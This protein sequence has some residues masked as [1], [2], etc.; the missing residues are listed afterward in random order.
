MGNEPRSSTESSILESSWEMPTKRAH[1]TP[2][3]TQIL[4]GKDFIG[5]LEVTRDTN[6]ST[7]GASSL[8]TMCL[9][10]I[11]VI[12]AEEQEWRLQENPD[13]KSDVEAETY[14]MLEDFGTSST[15]GWAPLRQVVRAHGIYLMEAAIRDELFDRER[16]T[17]LLSSCQTLGEEGVRQQITAAYLR[18]N[19]TDID[20]FAQRSIKDPFSKPGQFFDLPMASMWRF[21]GVR[22]ANDS[23]MRVLNEVLRRDST[24]SLSLTAGQVKSSWNYAIGK[25]MTADV[26][27]AVR[28]QE[29]LETILLHAS[30]IEPVTL[31]K[32]LMKSSQECKVLSQSRNAN[33]RGCIKDNLGLRRLNIDGEY[34]TMLEICVYVVT[35]ITLIDAS[36]TPQS[37]HNAR[38]I[39][40]RLIRQASLAVMR[41]YALDDAAGVV[42]K[43]DITHTTA[44]VLFADV[45][46]LILGHR[47]HC[48]TDYEDL[49]RER[50][51]FITYILM[52]KRPT[53]KPTPSPVNTTAKL[54][55]EIGRNLVKHAG[56]IGFKTMQ[57]VCDYLTQFTSHSPEETSLMKLIA[58][59][60][61][62][63]FAQKTNEP[64]HVEYASKVEA[65]VTK[66][67]QD[68]PTIQF[69]LGNR[70]ANL[71]WEEGLCEWV[72]ATPLPRELLRKTK[73]AVRNEASDESV[74]ETRYLGSDGGDVSPL[75]GKF[76]GQ[77]DSP[78][79]SLA[80]LN[81]TSPP[82]QT[83]TPTP[84]SSQDRKRK[85]PGPTSSSQSLHS[86]GSSS[87]K[88]Y[89]TSTGPSRHVADDDEEEED[90]LSAPQP[91]H[92][93][94]RDITNVALGK[95]QK[96]R[97]APGKER[98]VE[99]CELV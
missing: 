41:A 62:L 60:S 93:T 28:A 74:S 2:Q 94:L 70:P 44:T 35:L 72:T 46:I 90:E 78:R 96:P 63:M 45:I 12:M 73:L 52:N 87:Q 25:I 6:C 29:F 79:R 22:W 97:C 5:L 59:E 69:H 31:E 3:N 80:P 83:T 13:D 38:S 56:H 4:A 30:C 65:L 48:E 68:H 36:T 75:A 84:S 53:R 61:S 88:R 37:R 17:A 81:T 92:R 23:K 40:E 77:M 91:S 66:S 42:R 47:T 11:P 51:M 20:S 50:S 43:F 85:A 15:S 54:L 55:V 18:P 21:G 24:F 49:I 34:R 19:K 99:A 16:I 27:A 10:H 32:R 7:R 82:L 9:R 76:H 89:K 8:I 1:S 39:L 98:R 33:S 57:H 64:S 58:L 71:R 95:A 14:S 67:A 86:S 26:L